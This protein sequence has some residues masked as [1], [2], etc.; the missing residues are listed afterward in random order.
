MPNVVEFPQIVERG[1]GLDVHQQT[2]V[3]TIKG[4]GITEE[5]RTFGTF[6]CDLQTLKS[7]LTENK[8]TH[9]AMESTGV[10]WKPVYNIL[11]EDFQILL[12]NARHIKHV[13]GHK[14]DKKDSSW[15]AQLLLSGLLKGS[16][17][18]A[19]PSR[20]LRELY[21]YK[22]TLIA[23]RSAERNRLQKI[24]QDANIKLASVITD[25]FGAT[26]MAILE[27]ILHGHTA[28]AYLATLAKG[29]LV[30]KKAEL[31]LA[32]Q[33]NL[34]AHHLFML[35]IHKQVLDHLE[36]LL[37]EVGEQIKTYLSHYQQETELLQTI[38]GVGV[39]TAGA[40]IAEIG[41]DM[42][43][44]PSQKH[45]SSW[46]GV[47]PGNNES[48][49]KKK[50]TSITHGNKSLKTALVEAAWAASRTKKDTFLK[51]KYNSLVGRRGKKKALIAVGHKIL[52]AAYFIL[53]NKQEYREPD[54][55]VYREKRKQAQIGHYLKRLH[56][57]GVSP[58]LNDYQLQQ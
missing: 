44:F 13:P 18:P 41:C 34:T 10:Y 40:I 56:E 8:I 33:G 32:L 50:S 12:V 30:K 55:E 28:P 20:E 26:G 46:A 24:Y 45:L 47:C 48:A 31:Q 6:T 35:K 36:A 43:A 49:G 11:S 25:L 37:A 22:R 58:R 1:C 15:I 54:Q 2:V 19:R 9:L 38:P 14:T 52:C 7:W 17:I 42:Q 51:R 5:T 27:A 39:E 53:K 57:L 16:F 3:A 23:Q 4:S 21:R 29:S